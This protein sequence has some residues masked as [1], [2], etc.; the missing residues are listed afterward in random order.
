MVLSQ[1][2][3]P[4]TQHKRETFWTT[5]DIQNELAKH[6]KSQDIPTLKNLSAAIKRLRWPKIKTNGLVGYYL[7]LR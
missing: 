2:F 6:L 7:T 3:E 1:L 4:A 5:T